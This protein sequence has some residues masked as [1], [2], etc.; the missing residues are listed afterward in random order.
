MSTLEGKTIVWIEDD[1]FLG[2]LMAKK[3]SAEKANVVYAATG[4]DA[5]ERMK[6]IEPDLILSDVL[7]PGKDGFEILQEVK[8]DDRL[9][10]VPVILFSNLN[11]E[12]DIA[13]GKELGAQDFFVKSSVIPEQIVEKI[14][15]VVSERS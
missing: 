10:D 4:E 13:K 1:N 11:Q 8:A 9:K 12:E 5:L 6:D 15:E 2:G 3:I 7:L 14:K